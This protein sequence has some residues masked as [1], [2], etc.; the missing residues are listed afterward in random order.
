[1]AIVGATAGVLKDIAEIS[2]VVTEV[3]TAGDWWAVLRL[4]F[5][6]HPSAGVHRTAQ[7]QEGSL[8]LTWNPVG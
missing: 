6:D 2:A 5:G 8:S 7:Q 1:M 4:D 3:S